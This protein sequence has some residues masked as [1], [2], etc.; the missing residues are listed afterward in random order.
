[1]NAL[2]L[3][4]IASLLAFATAHAAGDEMPVETIVV[5]AKRPAF[6]ESGETILVVRVTAPA[7]VVP[8][9]VTVSPEDSVVIEPPKTVP[10]IEA[11]RLGAPKL[12]IA[13]PRNALALAETTQMQG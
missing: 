1:M 4:L 9:V 8:D 10:A 6:L 2:R 11:P 7:R 5:T 3:T 12:S 13:P